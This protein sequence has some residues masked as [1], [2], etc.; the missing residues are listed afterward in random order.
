MRPP[1]AS[2]ANIRPTF[3]LF[4]AAH[5]VLSELGADRQADRLEGRLEYFGSIMASPRGI[6]APVAEPKEYRS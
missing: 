5:F 6:R 1:A 3:L 2:C 4:G